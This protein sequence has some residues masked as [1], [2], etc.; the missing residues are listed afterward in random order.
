M[1]SVSA[2][3]AKQNFAAVLDNAQREPVMIRRH[4]RD[5]AVLVSPADYARLRG[6]KIEELRSLSERVSQV[7]ASR[8]MNEDVL[9]KLLADEEA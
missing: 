4:D 7:A 1:R 5:I 2:T 6:I 3:A 8:G 9:K